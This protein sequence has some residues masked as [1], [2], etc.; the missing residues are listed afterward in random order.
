MSPQLC[1]PQPQRAPPEALRARAPWADGGGWC[2]GGGLELLPLPL[3]S[4]LG[5]GPGRGWVSETS[6]SPLPTVFRSY[7]LCPGMAR[8]PWSPSSVSTFTLPFYSPH[9]S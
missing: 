9:Q 8:S 5:P 2:H 7:E 3:W 1:S 6:T 4:Q